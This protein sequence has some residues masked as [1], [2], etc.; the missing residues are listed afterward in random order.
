MSDGKK[1][2]S[3]LPGYLSVQMTACIFL[4]LPVL[5]MVL[6]FWLPESPYYSVIEN[7]PEEAR[8][9]LKWLLRKPEVELEFQQLKKDVERQI[10]ETGSW[11]DLFR[12]KSNRKALLACIF[13]RYGQQFAGIAAFEGYFQF[14]FRKAGATFF[15]PEVSAM[16]FSGTLWLVMTTFSIYL[17]RFGRRKLFIVST[18][19]CAVCLGV[20]SCYFYCDEFLDL[21]SIN[22]V[23]IV[24]LLVYVCFY[25]MGVGILPSLMAGELFSTS[26][27]TKALALANFMMGL[28]ALI[29]MYSFKILSSKIGLYAPFTFYSLM[30]LVFFGLSFSIVPE[31]RGKTLEEIQQD[32]KQSKKTKSVDSVINN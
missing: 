9:A 4:S 19:G 24:G 28:V 6:F 7:K 2:L 32:L 25:C 10:S 3:Y 23:P 13:V 27:K 14:I 30:S 11:S 21:T 12:I 18:L 20:E 17:D 1:L 26:I 22:W 15:S 5:F 29:V 8:K 16:F 31:T